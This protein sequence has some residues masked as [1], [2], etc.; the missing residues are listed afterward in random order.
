[1]VGERK[2]ELG[3]S[4]YYSLHNELG[5]NIPKPNLDESKDQ[6]FAITDCIDKGLVLSCH[7]IADGGI[8]TSLSEMTF[9]NKIGCS[10]NI[11][12]TLST[13]KVLF[14]ETGGF[15]VEIT[16]EN[17]EK[18]HSVF[19]SYGLNV[20]EIGIT[21]GALININELVELAVKGAKEAWENG[22]RDKL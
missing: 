18:V 10:V 19:S 13:G 12:S 15:V 1:M 21:G 20:F 4:V 6:I 2:D 8:A 9:K 11:E 3:G 16:R 14:S 5:A 7:D 22:L 17:Y